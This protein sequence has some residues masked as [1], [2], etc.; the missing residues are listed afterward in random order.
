MCFGELYSLLEINCVLD[1]ERS[2]QQFLPITIFVSEILFESVNSMVTFRDFFLQTH[3]Y[4]STI[5]SDWSVNSF[6]MV[7]GENFF[8]LSFC[9]KHDI[10]DNHGISI[11]GPDRTECVLRPG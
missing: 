3:G 11:C 4:E 2:Q 9:P 7:V 8:C 10:R 5:N 1:C 6:I